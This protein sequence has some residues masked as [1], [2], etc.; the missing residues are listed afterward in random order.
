MHKTPAL[1]RRW[2]A[3][4]GGNLPYPSSPDAIGVDLGLKLQDQDPELWQVLTGNA[5]ASLELQVMEGTF[6]DSAPTPQERQETD[7]KAEIAAILQRNDGNPFGC[8]AHHDGERWIEHRQR[9]D[10]DSFRLMQLDP[11]LAERLKLQ[12]NPPK[13]DPHALSAAAAAEVN[14]RLASIERAA[15][16][17]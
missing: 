11:A 2:I 3:A 16:G 17:Y 6:A 10:T 12:A 14:A 5:P 7:R 4:T 8:L 1:L 13:P 15:G 9:H